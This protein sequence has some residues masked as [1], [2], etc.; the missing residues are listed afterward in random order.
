MRSRETLLVREIM[1]DDVRVLAPTDSILKAACRMRD[2]GIGSLPVVLGDK[3]I[4]YLTDRDLVVRG[5]A[6]G[7][8][9]GTAVR[10]LMSEELV[11]CSEEDLVDVA[12]ATMAKHQ[13]RRLPVLSR[14]GRLVGILSLGDIATRGNEE[15]AEEALAEISEPPLP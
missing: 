1:T 8:D 12:A 14:S 2:E 10:Q 11:C 7:M 9:L 5:L 4:G 6:A 3:P 15:A 13:I